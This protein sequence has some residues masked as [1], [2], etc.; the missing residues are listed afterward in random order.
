MQTVAFMAF[1]IETQTLKGI[2]TAIYFILTCEIL[3]A[4]GCQGEEEFSAEKHTCVNLVLMTFCIGA[5]HIIVDRLAG[6]ARTRHTMCKL[7]AC[8][9]LA[10]L[11]N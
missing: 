4:G 11:R 1:C 10:L 9:N 7:S 8:A 3:T 6:I 2:L 5:L